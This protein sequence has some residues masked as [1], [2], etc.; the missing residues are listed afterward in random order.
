MIEA[1][2]LSRRVPPSAIVALLGLT[3]DRQVRGTRALAFGLLHA[4]PAL[5]AVLTRTYASES[6]FEQLED[7]LV[8][9]L[10]PQAV[11]PLTALLFAAGMVTD[12]VE[13]QTMTYLLIRPIPKW[14]IYFA[15]VAATVLVTSLLASFSMLAAL[16][17][18]H[19]G[20]PGLVG[21][22]LATR[23][24]VLCAT[25]ILSLAVY[26]P[27]FGVLG[28]VVRRSLIFGVVY[29]VVLEGLLAN[30]DFVVR[31][32][33]VMYWVRILWI[34]WL[35]VPGKPWSIASDSMPTAST[36]LSVL[37]VAGAVL[38]VVGAWIFSE[39]EFRVKTSD[40]A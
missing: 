19:W 20:E 25:S 13:E 4:L 3:I 21:E 40:A 1:P 29:T 6:D 7:L 16:A 35:G 8:F 24:P 33:T 12:D 14:A 39:R 22:I 30:I 32:A 18:I 36:A 17:A 37:L 28:L 38:A 34:R 2:P 15:K 31:R 10:I 5:V 11:I 23:G 27:I 9:G 26:V